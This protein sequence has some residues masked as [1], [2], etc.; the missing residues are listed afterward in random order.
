MHC[1]MRQN[2]SDIYADCNATP[3]HYY[4]YRVIIPIQ[5]ETIYFRWSENQR[6]E[7]ISREIDALPEY[8]KYTRYTISTQDFDTSLRVTRRDNAIMR[9]YSRGK[10]GRPV[11]VK[12]I[13]NEI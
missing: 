10:Y 2:S 11:T 7:R 13:A 12:V 4:D 6:G 1:R 8:S 5:T 3:S 9:N